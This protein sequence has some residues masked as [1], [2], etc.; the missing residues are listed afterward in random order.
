MEDEK[1]WLYTTH[2]SKYKKPKIIG[3]LAIINGRPSIAFVKDGKVESYLPLDE[4]CEQ[5][6]NS[7]IKSIVVK[8]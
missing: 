3:R 6:K 8:F 7:D 5:I 1:T 2:C 4:A